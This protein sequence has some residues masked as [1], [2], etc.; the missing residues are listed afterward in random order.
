MPHEK[1]P[2]NVLSTILGKFYEK[3]TS[4]L[5]F[6]ELTALNAQV[7]AET[8][9]PSELGDGIRQG[10]FN[11]ICP[12]T[13]M[14]VSSKMFDSHGNINTVT[15]ETEVVMTVVCGACHKEHPVSVVSLPKLFSMP[16]LVEVEC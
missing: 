12:E 6:D 15:S 1:Y 9:F 8:A 13:G 14:L 4:G 7:R 11:F 10:T 16:L 2:T 3:L 5:T